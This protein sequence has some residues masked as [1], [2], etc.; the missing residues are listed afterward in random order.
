MGQ[1]QSRTDAGSAIAFRAYTDAERD[2]LRLLQ[3][4]AAGRPLRTPTSPATA[5]AV[6]ASLASPS[7]TI[8]LVPSSLPPP[9]S[10]LLAAV[11]PPNEPIPL[12]AAVAVLRAALLASPPAATLGRPRD[13]R[14]RAAHL[15][16]DDEEEAE[17]AAEPVVEPLDGAAGGNE[18]LAAAA[19]PATLH[20]A[21]DPDVVPAPLESSSSSSSTNLRVVRSQAGRAAVSPLPV[22]KLSPYLAATLASAT[23]VLPDHVPVRMSDLES[24]VNVG[25][26]SKGLVALSPAIALLKPTATVLQL[27]CNQLTSVPPHLG[28]LTQLTVLSLAKNKLAAVPPE[29]AH[30]AQLVELDLS[31]NVLG[32][33]PAALGQL[34]RLHVLRVDHNRL[35][36]LPPQLGRLAQ[37]VTLDASENPLAVLPAE[38][39]RLKHLRKLRTR[40]C[41]LLALPGSGVYGLR[42]FPDPASRVPSLR[43]LAARAIVT[44]NTLVT[45]GDLPTDLAAYLT[46]F[47][48]CTFCNGPYFAHRVVRTKR[49][50]KNEVNLP[51]V[52]HMCADHW[53]SERQRVAA[54]FATPTCVTTADPDN[55]AHLA[56]GEAVVAVRG[57]PMVPAVPAPAVLAAVGVGGVV[58]PPVPLATPPR[59]RAGSLPA[60][61]VARATRRSREPSSRR[62]SSDGVPLPMTP[63]SVSADLSL[64]SS[65]ACLTPSASDDDDAS[66]S[67]LEDDE[68]NPFDP[69]SYAPLTSG[70]VAALAAAIALPPLPLLV[71]ATPTPPPAPPSTPSGT[72]GRPRAA[73]ASAAAKKMLKRSASVPLG[74]PRRRSGMQASASEP[75]L[76]NEMDQPP[77]PPLPEI[78]AAADGTPVVVVGRDGALTPI[79]E[80][81]SGKAGRRWSGVA[82]LVARV[83][84]GRWR[85]EAAGSASSAGRA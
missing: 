55:P 42:D 49:I 8:T 54:M 39:A 35:T 18:D 33:L 77:V 69:A 75:A 4:R 45:L 44:S 19:E 40:G 1:S 83:R 46:S 57:R 27:C 67:E 13:S 12:D 36:G 17:H 2:L 81:S 30:L 41:P 73:S 6:A 32:D 60:A 38:L 80:E 74:G 31:H 34:R 9:L 79:A 23:V 84:F 20:P 70:P 15:D 82:G 56:A 11:Y 25:L 68:G 59:S 43:E 47:Q 50:V 5:A 85:A 76:L 29:I 52:Y 58:T 66:D 26:C 53:S 63:A 71:P 78:V 62:G 48:T 22:A 65:T 28:Y 61:I 64:A 3:D 16:D 24:L 21:A 14:A 37:L 7:A 72:A 51:L 10:A